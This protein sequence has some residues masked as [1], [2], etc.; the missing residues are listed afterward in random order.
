[1][2]SL[3]DLPV[4]ATWNFIM[5]SLPTKVPLIT[6]PFSYQIW[7]NSYTPATSSNLYSGLGTSAGRKISK[8]MV[9]RKDIG[10]CVPNS[11]GVVQNRLKKSHMFAWWFVQ[12]NLINRVTSR[13]KMLALIKPESTSGGLFKVATIMRWSYYWSGYKVRFHCIYIL[14][15]TWRGPATITYSP[16]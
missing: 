9:I 8:C 6:Q 4:A 10:K 13:A 12:W 11:S 15:A 5:R 7:W 1:M 16:Q 14:T 3:I 2:I